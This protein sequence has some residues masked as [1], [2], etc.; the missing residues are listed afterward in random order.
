MDMLNSQTDLSKPIQNIG[1]LEILFSSLTGTDCFGQITTLS[2]LHYNF[3]FVLGH[4]DLFEID[5]V[6][7]T[8]VP[9]DL[10]LFNGLLS[11]LRRH[12]FNIHFL[13][14]KL[15]TCGYVTDKVGLAESSLAKEFL[16]SIDFVFVFDYLNFHSDLYYVICY[17]KYVIFTYSHFQYHFYLFV[18]WNL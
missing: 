10:S 15:L 8:Q 2:V 3:E 16:P 17:I 13:D 12:M 4:V 5:Y 1:L 18:G 9:K 14:D 7:M 6:G 11:F